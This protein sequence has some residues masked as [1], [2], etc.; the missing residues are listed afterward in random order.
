MSR[1]PREP[2]PPRRRARARHGRRRRVRATRPSPTALIAAVVRAGDRRLPLAPAH[3]RELALRPPVRA[4]ADPARGGAG[5]LG[6]DPARAGAAAGAGPLARRPS[7]AAARRGLVARWPS[8]RW[9]CACSRWCCWA[10][11]WRG[12]QTSAPRR[13]PRG[14]GHR[15]RHHAGSVGLDGGDRSAAQPAGRRQGGHPR[16]RAPAADRSHRPGGVRARR[17]HLRAADP[18]SRRLA[19]HAGRAAARA[20]STARARPSATAWA[21]RWPGCGARTRAPR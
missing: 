8:C 5:A 11:R 12:P 15:H 18:R 9:C 19:A 13:R 21:W 7:S 3:A 4:G 1:A 2:A 20:S 17:L 10:W 16:L 6:G 14:R